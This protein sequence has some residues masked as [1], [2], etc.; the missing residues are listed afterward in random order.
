[1]KFLFFLV[2]F[3]FLTFFSK[4]AWGQNSNI[5]FEH[6]THEQGLSQSSVFS[7]V[8]DSIGFIW[9]ATEDGLNRFDGLTCKVFRHDAR[10]STSVAS[11][12]IKKLF[13]DGKQRMWVITSNGQLDRYL[14]QTET[15]KH[16]HLHFKAPDGREFNRVA[17]IAQNDSGEIWVG[18][19]SGHL[20]RLDAQAD[21]FSPCPFNKKFFPNPILLQVLHFD[22][23]GNL[24]LG[25]WGGLFKADLQNGTLQSFSWAQGRPINMVLDLAEDKSGNLWMVTAG[26]GVRYFDLQKEKF[27]TFHHN[28]QNSMGLSSNRTMSIL[29]DSQSNVWIGTID[30]GVNFLPHGSIQFVH[31]RHNPHEP[32]SLAN[33]AVLSIYEDR[34]GNIWFGHYHGGVSR[35][36]PRRS[37]FHYFVHDANDP[38]SLSNDMVLAVYQD[39]TGTLWVGTDG[40]GVNALRPGEKFFRHYLT[41]S[42]PHT[43]NSIPAIYETL[44]GTL[45]LGTDV[46]GQA[47]GGLIF[48]FDRQTN[49]FN[50]FDL[51]RPEFGGVAAFCQ[52]KRGILWV[53]TYNEGL[54]SYDPQSGEVHQFQFERNN[55]N[56]L[57]GNAVLALLNDQKGQLWIGTL[58]RGLNC[59]DPLKHHFKHY[60]SQP[61]NPQSLAGNSVWSLA[62][63]VN[64]NLWIGTNGGLSLFLPQSDSFRSFTS[65][66]GLPG[67]MIYGILPD[68]QGNLWLSTNHGLA[69]FNSR[70][71]SVKR[72]DTSDGLLNLEFIQGAYCKGQ[73]G[74]FYFGGNKGL[75]YFNPQ[76]IK[77]SNVVPPVVITDF[78]VKGKPVSLPSALPFTKRIKLSYRQNFFTFKFAAL[79]YHAPGKNQYAYQLQGVDDDWVACGSRR[80]ADYTDIA[81]GNYMFR[82]KATNSDGIWS[83][84]QASVEIVILPP[85]WQTWWFRL[86]LLIALLALLQAFHRYRVNK[87]LAVER[88]RWRIARD[89]HDDVSATITGI[90]YFSEALEQQVGKQ[91][92]QVKKLFALIHESI[93]NVQ[94]SMSEIIWSINPENDHWESILPKFRRFASELCE[95]KGINYLIEIPDELFSKELEMEKRRNVW[96]ILKEIVN[97]AVKHSQCENLTVLMKPDKA[98]LL[99]TIADDGRGFDENKISEGN[100]LQNIRRRAEKI[101]VTVQLFTAPGQGTRWELRI[102]LQ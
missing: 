1:M 32:F 73:N 94:E 53:G 64:G 90:A 78:L 15:F 21:R 77:S 13:V 47:P 19:T 56:S 63:D 12:G 95:S 102:P 51:I 87:L 25:T 79:D 29:V 2:I 18:L 30:A 36:D 46:S 101:G 72:F 76:E 31:Y 55:P 45:W 33:G 16:Y 4:T 100:G 70:N 99:V 80:F 11:S 40:G 34:S 67:N 35:Y 52:D 9:L 69:Y 39:H 91:D 10:D 49:R 96:L 26:S 28:P 89:L 27:T 43:S 22:R 48:H 86:L 54:F 83:R 37:P 3:C 23:Q 58:E 42:G 61:Q 85:F 93:R 14:A 8:E 81:P 92:A 41:K 97:N 50:R 68:A 5:R 60:K 38:G 6:I 57:S 66:D 17:S 82:V 24:W 59:Y 98:E 75:T 88:T 71:F 20:F 84:H 44:D 7:I 62:Q 65:Q 74:M